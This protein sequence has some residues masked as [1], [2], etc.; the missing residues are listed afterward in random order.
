[1][2][3]FRRLPVHLS[4]GASLILLAACVSFAA[5]NARSVLSACGTEW[6]NIHKNNPDLI[7]VYVQQK[8]DSRIDAQ[9]YEGT[10]PAMLIFVFAGGKKHTVT[11]TPLGQ[12]QNG[13]WTQIKE[14]DW[15]YG[16]MSQDFRPDIECA[17]W[18][19]R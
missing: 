1:M 14:D 3:L 11:Y 13:I 8:P 18:Q 9:D 19:S 10:H 15:V 12:V 16:V 5:D 2:E 4:L 6:V 17:Y 7:G